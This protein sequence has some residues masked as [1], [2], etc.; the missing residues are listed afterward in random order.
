[1]KR[2]LSI[3]FAL[4]ALTLV[5]APGKSDPVAEGYPDWQGISAKS[6]IMGREIC[7]SD[8]RHKIVVVL[9]VEM[10]EKLGSQ[11]I[12]AGDIAALNP[13]AA[14]SFGNNWETRVLDR[15]LVFVVSVRGNAKNPKDDILAALKP[16]K[17]AD[18]SVSRKLSNYRSVSV[19]FYSNLVMA[20]GP[21]TTG[22]RPYVYV[23]GA[24]GTKPLY[25]GAVT[26]KSVKDVRAAVTK[27]RKRLAAAGFKWEPFL[28]SVTEPKNA[29]FLK[30]MEK[31]KAGKASPMEPVAKALQKDILSK[32]AEKAKEAQILFDA[33]NQ[34]RDDLVLRIR[35]EAN[36]CP[37][38]AAYDVQQLLLFW[39][40]EAKKLSMVKA[41]LK[42]MPEANKLAQV[43]CKM[44][45]WSDPD[46]MCK[47]ASEAK[48]IV[49]E[50]NKLK[51]DLEK[52]K[53]S[54][55]I[56]VQNGALLVDGQ[57]DELIAVIPTKVPEK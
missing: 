50:L 32:D 22:K 36:E 41:K 21:D 7:P 17:D 48:K 39:P 18:E 43:F 46:F 15:S 38:R 1:M 4:G 49:A 24:E 45:A 42:Q 30:A 12:A 31:G 44:M 2:T 14:S 5:G 52:L 11:F 16:P 53:E 10:G 33:L 8:L 51:K 23:M 9:E 34:T 20:D 13:L 29:V 28:G 26:A 19:P 56:A 40:G 54:K 47:N 37:H 57:I 55:T 3:L 35:M 6:Y 25:E 27:E